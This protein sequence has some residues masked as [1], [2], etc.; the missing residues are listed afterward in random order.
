MGLIGSVYTLGEDDQNTFSEFFPVLYEEVF[1]QYSDDE[2]QDVIV[3]FRDLD[4]HD[5][6]FEEDGEIRYG[7]SMEV[8]DY[9]VIRSGSDALI[10]LEYEGEKRS[11]I[12]RSATRWAY[13][14]FDPSDDTISYM[15]VHK[16]VDR[17]GGPAFASPNDINFA[18][19]MEQL[20]YVHGDRRVRHYRGMAVTSPR[21]FLFRE[22]KGFPAP[23]KFIDI[24]VE[25]G[26]V[27]MEQTLART[28]DDLPEDIILEAEELSPKMK[29]FALKLRAAEGED[30]LPMK[31]AALAIA[32]KALDI[33]QR[34]EAATQPPLPSPEDIQG[35]LES[36]GLGGVVTEIMGPLPPELLDA[37]KSSPQ[38]ATAA[39]PVDETP[40]GFQPPTIEYIEDAPKRA[41]RPPSIFDLP[42]IDDLD[43]PN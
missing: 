3:L 17:D 23:S 9:T 20:D 6:S 27:M 15:L 2:E 43:K 8:L 5:A 36:L 25:F 30:R 14:R 19:A 41:E 39:E 10:D 22:A 12:L 37:L 11:E 33:A 29:E 13:E 16:H 21:D 34:A 38:F 24:D 40:L 4:G 1:N 18:N 7:G 42:A 32:G 31:I 26:A 35:I 28:R